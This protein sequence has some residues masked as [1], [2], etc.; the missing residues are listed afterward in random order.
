MALGQPPDAA[1]Q[2]MPCHE[3]MA[4]GHPGGVRPVARPLP[5]AMSLNNIN[6]YNRPHV[7]SSRSFPFRGRCRFRHAVGG[8]HPF[9]GNRV[10]SRARGGH[11][12]SADQR[13]DLGAGHRHGRDITQH[14]L[15]ILGIA[16]GRSRVVDFTLAAG[17]VGIARRR[18][19]IGSWQG[20]CETPQRYWLVAHAPN[21]I[22]SVA[23]DLLLVF[24]SLRKA[25]PSLRSG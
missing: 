20:R 12:P 23:K 7:A 13:L 22:L 19:S 14:R 17:W 15:G 6:G 4:L 5:S 18:A 8:L 11:E 1:L 25:D 21:V 2:S 9:R 24:C 16:C 3:A 10:S